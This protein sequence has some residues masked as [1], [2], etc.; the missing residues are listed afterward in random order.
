MV[1]RHAD[2]QPVAVALAQIEQGR[3][4]LVHRLHRVGQ[5]QRA[6]PPTEREIE[7]GGKFRVHERL[8]AGKAD[9]TG[10]EPDRGDLVEVSA[11]FRRAQIGEPV[12]FRRGLDIAIMAGKIAERAGVEPQRVERAQRDL[13]PRLAGGSN[14][15]ILKLARIDPRWRGGERLGHCPLR[16]AWKR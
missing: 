7:H 16:V 9:Q 10:A 13:R 3:L 11:D 1:D 8:A 5:H 12:V 2:G 15:R 6:E 4:L 14:E